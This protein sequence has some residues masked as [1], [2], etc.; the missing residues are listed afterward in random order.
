MGRHAG[1]VGRRHR[2]DRGQNRRQHGGNPD[3]EGH[4]RG[5]QEEIRRGDRRER[6]RRHAEQR[7]RLRVHEPV[8]VEHGSQHPDGD[9]QVVRRERPAVRDRFGETPRIPEAV[10]SR[11]VHHRRPEAERREGRHQRHGDGGAGVREHARTEGIRLHPRGYQARPSRV[12]VRLGHRRAE[13]SGEDVR[14]ILQKRRVAETGDGEGL[15]QAQRLQGAGP[16]HDG[17]RLPERPEDLE[18]EQERRKTRHGRLRGGRF[19]LHGRRTDQFPEEI[20]GERHGIHRRGALRRACQLREHRDR[21]PP[22]GE[23][24]PDAESVLLGRG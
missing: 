20:S 16:G 21:Q 9:A 11:G 4:L 10:A 24:R 19:R 12:R 1:G 7:P 14:G 22:R 17:H 6:P 13:G 5:V 18:T 23:V 3:Q 2:E 8:H 15:Q